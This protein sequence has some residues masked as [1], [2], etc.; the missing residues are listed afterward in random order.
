MEYRSKEKV[1]QLGNEIM[2]L[3]KTIS[4]LSKQK[5][6]NEIR[7]M[8]NKR[9]ENFINKGMNNGI[10]GR[11]TMKIDLRDNPKKSESSVV[12]SVKC[13]KQSDVGDAMLRPQSLISDKDLRKREAIVEHIP[14]E[15]CPRSLNPKQSEKD[16]LYWLD[17]AN[18]KHMKF[19]ADFLK[20][21]DYEYIYYRRL[22]IPFVVVLIDLLYFYIKVL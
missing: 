7:E 5:K 18:R 21:L 1:V 3:S 15:F 14:H 9:E 19:Q 13:T 17:K 11:E 8:Q 2:S 4:K 22:T 12:R 10:L 16:Y 20:R 6:Q